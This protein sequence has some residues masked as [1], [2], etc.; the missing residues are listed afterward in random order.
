M[1][2]SERNDLRKCD[3]R[4]DLAEPETERTKPAS[5]AAP[6][7]LIARVGFF[8]V[9]YGLYTVIKAI[10]GDDLL[11][12]QDV[13]WGVLNIAIGA[14][15]VGAG[16]ATD[17]SPEDQPERDDEAEAIKISVL[18]RRKRPP[19]GLYLRSFSTTATL[20]VHRTSLVLPYGV[21]L[22]SGE[23]PEA[24]VELES[25]LASAMRDTHTIPLIGLGHP[26]EHF[27]SG[28]IRTED[29]SWQYLAEQLIRCA[30]VIFA[31]PG[32][33]PGTLWELQHLKETGRLWKTILLMPPET[34]DA[35]WPMAWRNTKLACASI[36]LMLPDYEKQGMFF[37]L[38]DDGTQ[39]L[40]R[41]LPRRLRPV[42]VLR[43]LEPFRE[44]LRK[45]LEGRGD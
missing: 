38:G 26:G 11:R 15:L 39:K 3:A 10:V 7:T 35:D 40:K 24:V 19:F 8:F 6:P 4:D 43:T 13:L 41:S 22:G 25:L 14:I 2:T 32:D 34:P 9:G 42:A 23:S 5:T 21:Y 45:Q 20:T 1:S 28:R 18:R 37:A 44:A 29:K 33:S 27:G 36:G 16:N 30:E 31:V 17:P 12:G